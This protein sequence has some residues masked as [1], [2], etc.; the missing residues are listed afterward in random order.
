[1]PTPA[2]TAI[3]HMRAGT[4]SPG[5]TWRLRGFLRALAPALADPHWVALAGRACRIWQ[6][7]YR[8]D[9][10]PLVVATIGEASEVAQWLVAS[11]LPA[12]HLALYLPADGPG[13]AD[14]SE[15]V[16][17]APPLDACVIRS[18]SVPPARAQYRAQRRQRIG[19]QLLENSDAPLTS[20]AQLHRLLHVLSIW[21][22]IRVPD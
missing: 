18:G 14:L 20:M 16:S 6:A 4:R 2:S 15:H 12:S 1:M 13:R 3:R 7:R 10:T 21:D 9:C 11:K 22:R 19:V 8:G 5:E 17:R